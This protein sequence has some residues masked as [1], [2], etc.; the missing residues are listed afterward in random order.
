[1]D[2]YS[3]YPEVHIIKSTGMKELTKVLNQI[4]RTQKWPKEIWSNGGPPCNSDKWPERFNQNLKLVILAADTEGKDS[5]LHKW[6]KTN[7]LML[8]RDVE[9]KLPRIHKKSKGKHHNDT[10][11]RDTEAQKE[12]KKKYNKTRNVEFKVGDWA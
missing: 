3:R 11:K 4:M 12:R 6:G 9:M 1:M 5:T 10:K 7:M 8:N 2:L